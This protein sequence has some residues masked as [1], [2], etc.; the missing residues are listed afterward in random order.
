MTSPRLR[1]AA[2]AVLISFTGVLARLA[3]IALLTFIP[4]GVPA[5]DGQA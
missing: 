4:V 3:G 1:L 2:G 5:T